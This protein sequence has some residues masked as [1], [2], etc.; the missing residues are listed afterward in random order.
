MP[1]MKHLCMEKHVSVLFR[2]GDYLL[3]WTLL[4]AACPVDNV[5][6]LVPYSRKPHIYNN[7]L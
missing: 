7:L 6:I 5:V 4:D 1:C 3:E 2:K